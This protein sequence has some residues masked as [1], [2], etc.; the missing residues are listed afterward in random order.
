MSCVEQLPEEPPKTAQDI[1][2]ILFRFP[3]GEREA[4]RFNGTDK[5]KV[6][7]LYRAACFLT[8]PVPAI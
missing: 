1:T 5:L 4:R 8:N 6:L 3:G 2:N 7:T